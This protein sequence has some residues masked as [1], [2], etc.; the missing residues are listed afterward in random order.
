MGGLQWYDWIQ[1]TN[2]FASI[3]FGILFSFILAV[4]AWLDTKEIKKS[5]LFFLL[6]I[7]VA[8]VLVLILYVFGYYS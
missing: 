7:I 3:F 6:G 4:I 8:M 2:P 1:P 5:F